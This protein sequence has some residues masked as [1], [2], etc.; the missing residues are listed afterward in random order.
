M[1]R[2]ALRSAATCAGADAAMFPHRPVML[3]AALAGLAV[4]EGGLYVDATYG[5]GGHSAEIL[6][7]L[8]GSGML[9]AFDQDP[10]ACA[11]AWR[12]FGAQPNFRIHAA[13]FAQLGEVARAE[14][15][16]DRAA[17]VLFDLGVSSPQ[18][19]DAARG[20]SFL[21]EG[22][23]DMRMNP[24]VGEPAS[25]W[26]ARAKDSEI[27][28]VLWRLG[29]ERHSRRIARAIVS[30]RA[31]AP[32][33]TTTQLAEL[34]ARV[35]PGP[36]Q[37]IH[38]ATRSF[39]AIR[40]F[41]NRELEVLA[42]ALAQATEVLAPGGRLVVISFHSLEDRIVKRFIREAGGAKGDVFTHARF[43]P[44]AAPSSSPVL[45]AISRVFPDDDEIAVNP[46]ARSAVLRVAEK[47]A[48]ARA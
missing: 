47:V 22:P 24:Q 15:W 3:D 16:A 9:H 39:Q 2:A 17:G 32:I 35:M 30:A 25:A 18:L 46:R 40:L 7:R 10:E 37:K 43:A 14:G 28:D 12:S 42:E 31:E 41:I 48:E 44:P 33:E 21:R 5:R 27:A 4:H 45:R 19:D 1:I 29:E 38:P 34:I 23:L 11:Q 6:A 36:R 20:F 26:L 13:N 8:H